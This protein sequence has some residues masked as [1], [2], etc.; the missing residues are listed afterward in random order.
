[1]K[2][3][4][5]D[6]VERFSNRVENYVKYRPHYPPAVLE[7]FRAE[8]GLTPDSIVADIG[9][10]TGISSELFLK[11]GNTV[12]GVE[13]N[14]KMREAAERYLQEFQKF[15]SVDGTAEATGLADDLVDVVVAG[16]AFHWFDPVGAKREFRRILKD[17]GYVALMWNERQLDTTPFLREYEAFLIKYSKDYEVVRHDTFD[18]SRLSD[19][20]GNGIRRKA[21]P[22]SQ[23]FDFDGIK[24][25]LLSAS[26]VPAEDDARFQ[27]MV[28]ELRSLFAKHAQN[29]RITVFYDT[30]VYYTQY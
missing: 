12:Y 11:N 13:P 28:S 14:A 8:M 17:G 16:Q 7:L 18:A 9:A 4:T 23:E 30:N 27:A 2:S 21:F 3:Q 24:G 5:G 6:T 29:D 25:R 22:N 1:M 10:G 20:F 15:H 19:I 26:Y